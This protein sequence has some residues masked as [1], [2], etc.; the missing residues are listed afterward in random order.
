MY[1]ACFPSMGQQGHNPSI[2]PSDD[3]N[4][5]KNANLIEITSE[6]SM[7]SNKELRIFYFMDLLTL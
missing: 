7:I 1:S 2:V 5:G 3:L 4:I 6:I